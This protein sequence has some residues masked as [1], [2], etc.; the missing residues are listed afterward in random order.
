MSYHSLFI[1]FVFCA[2]ASVFLLIAYATTR[3]GG[4]G[5]GFEECEWRLLRWDVLVLLFLL[6]CFLFGLSAEFRH[7]DCLANPKLCEP[8]APCQ[9]HN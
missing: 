9:K 1:F 3:C 4:P 2:F 6:P 8:C 5:S 7:R